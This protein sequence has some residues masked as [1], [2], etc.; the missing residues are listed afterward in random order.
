MGCG[1]LRDDPMTAP[2]A[3]PGASALPRVPD[4]EEVTP[5]EHLRAR[6]IDILPVE[7]L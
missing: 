3:H 6:A 2:N 7:L 4:P 5:E 1:I